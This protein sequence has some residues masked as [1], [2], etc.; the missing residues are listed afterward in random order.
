M[1]S[2]GASNFVY[3]Y[4][5]NAF[6]AVYRNVVVG[7]KKADI[8]AVT[9]LLIAS[10][11][12]V[13]NVLATTPLWVAGT[14]LTVQNKKAIAGNDKGAATEKPYTGVFDCLT[15]IIK[16]EGNFVGDGLIP[17]SL[18]C[19]PGVLALWNGVGPSLLLVS[20]PSIQ[21]VT[22]KLYRQRLNPACA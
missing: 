6:K 2:L 12:G 16:N 5:Y 18:A 14:R 20:N 4:T 13:I 1:V 17:T 10:T 8:G 9:N 22:C 11:A 7:D 3:F 21:F 15:K 19:A